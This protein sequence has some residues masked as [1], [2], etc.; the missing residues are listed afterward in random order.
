MP[1]PKGRDKGKTP[2]QK[3]AEA[4]ARHKRY[5]ELRD[6]GMDMQDAAREVGIDVG[7]S[8]RRYERWYQAHRRGEI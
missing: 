4:D 1:W 3:R 2:E 6:S 7:T 8:D 5:Y